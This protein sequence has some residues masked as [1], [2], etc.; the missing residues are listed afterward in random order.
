MTLLEGRQIMAISI[1]DLAAALALICF[2]VGL[3]ALMDPLARLL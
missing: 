2:A 1:R 3:V